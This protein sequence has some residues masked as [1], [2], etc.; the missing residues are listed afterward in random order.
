MHYLSSDSETYPD[1]W[2]LVETD[3]EG[4]VEGRGQMDGRLAGAAG[5]EPGPLGGLLTCQEQGEGGS[6]GPSCGR[7]DLATQNHVMNV[8]V[9]ESDRI[10]D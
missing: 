6:P 7:S 1:Q 8:T 4:G 2:A 5:T 3:G 9:P 10:V